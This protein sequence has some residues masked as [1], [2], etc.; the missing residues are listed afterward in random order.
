ME[1]GY[2]IE[3]VVV[4]EEEDGRRVDQGTKGKVVELGLGKGVVMKL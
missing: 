3:V 4:K 2:D 1:I